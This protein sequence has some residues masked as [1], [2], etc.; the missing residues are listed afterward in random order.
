MKKPDV[1]RFIGEA[2]FALGNM[3]I[4]KE[5]LFRYVNYQENAPDQDIILAKIAEIFLMQGEL[6]AAKQVVCFYPEILHRIP[7]ET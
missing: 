2:H 6:E 1:F 5:H 3:E 7:K 4:S